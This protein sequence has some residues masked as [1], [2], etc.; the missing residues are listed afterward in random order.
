MCKVMLMAGIKEKNT[1]NVYNFSTVIGQLMSKSNTD[2]LGYV[3]MTKD[4]KLYGQR[5]LD[6]DDAWVEKY[7]ANP[8]AVRA[9]K[10]FPG[11][12]EDKL[13]QETT[14]EMNS[15]GEENWADTVAIMLH[16]RFATSAKGM[17]NTHP[18]VTT[19][20]KHALIHNGVI[21]N[22]K[23]FKLTLS[24]CDSEAILVSYLNRDVLSSPKNIQLSVN[25]L[26]GYYAAGIMS[27]DTKSMD[28]FRSGARLSFA[29]VSEL[30]TYVFSTDGKDIEEAC[31]ML[32]YKCG[33]VFEFKSE[34]FM[35]LDAI[36]G[37]LIGSVLR[38]TE[39]KVITPSY[40]GHKEYTG[41]NYYGAAP[42]SKGILSS[43][44]VVRK[45]SDMEIQQDTLLYGSGA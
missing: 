22:D 45:L 13:L 44:G 41:T 39:R 10:K 34:H 16:T 8:H 5:W 2:G 9:H 15:F 4:G 21:R 3:A 38:F 11:L 35:R 6:N 17:R 33:D 27:A 31:R 20:N 14:P 24:T 43:R 28:I 30:G 1:S 42:T 18:F 25:E 36:T 26:E 40:M 12:I 37:N 7:S 32:K 23:D 19:D 29:Y